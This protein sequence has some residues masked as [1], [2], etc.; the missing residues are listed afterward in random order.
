MRKCKNVVNKSSTTFLIVSTDSGNR[1]NL[2]KKIPTQITQASKL[3]FW[4]SLFHKLDNA[5]NA[6]RLLRQGVNKHI[7]RMHVL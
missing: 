6:D 1:R 5:V 2:L 3:R 4:E 7:G